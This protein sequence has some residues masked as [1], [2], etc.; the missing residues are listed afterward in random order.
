M[1]QT[2]SSTTAEAEVRAA[3]DSWVQAVCTRDVKKI[4]SHYA[5][6]VLAF[7]AVGPLR[8]NGAEAYGKHWATCMEM[9]AGPM[10]FKIDELKTT[11]EEEISFS[12]FLVYCGG[13][14][15]D[16]NEK[17]SWMRATSCHRRENGQWRIAHEHFSAPFDMES[18]KAL[19]DL[20]P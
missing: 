5:A 18:T 13:T 3:L 7:D 8:F 2:V 15:Q 1:N 9:C 4:M 10:V 19:F 17:A 6:D 16:G 14:D 20:K 12:H 11:A